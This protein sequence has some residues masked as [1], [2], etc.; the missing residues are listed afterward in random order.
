MIEGSFNSH[1]S[2][3]SS[4]DST[5]SPSILRLLKPPPIS[6]P[7]HA[8]TALSREETS[9]VRTAIWIA[10]EDSTK[11]T[12]ATGLGQYL[13]Y[14]EE[15]RLDKEKQFPVSEARMADFLTYA[16]GKVSREYTRNWFQ[17]VRWYHQYW[18]MKFEYTE[19]TPLIRSTINAVK[20]TEPSSS[21]RAKRPPVTLEL[22]RII[23]E[24]INHEDAKDVAIWA[25]SAMCF[26]GLLRLGEAVVESEKKFNKDRHVRRDSISWITDTLGRHHFQLSIPR[27]KTSITGAVVFIRGEKERA[28]DPVV[29]MNRHLMKSPTSAEAALFSYGTNG[30]KV[31]TKYQVQKRIGSILE[32]ACPG[33]KGHCFR[34]GGLLRLLLD[35]H[36]FEVARLQGRWTN[37]G[38]W[39]V[40]LREHA[41][42]LQKHL[43]VESSDWSTVAAGDSRKVEE[44]IRR[45]QRAE[46][47]AATTN[48]L[49]TLRSNLSP[50]FITTTQFTPPQSKS[51][52]T[53]HSAHNTQLGIFKR[54]R[55]DPHSRSISVERRRRIE[56]RR[57][58]TASRFVS[59]RTKWGK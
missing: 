21:K 11:K 15:K 26:A 44:E 28:I 56:T 17:G 34:I 59:V 23:Y 30:K 31:I 45:R 6:T 57:I 41:V 32:S 29:A 12:Y 24:N 58:V 47:S 7:L 35:G 50:S 2:I 54:Q 4:L 18:G 55:I 46:A 14:C 48:T 52:T 43:G 22:M 19:S 36:S 53:Q 27:T 25:C 20:K 37:G 9:R 33:F 38:C 8:F 39:Q 5:T 1:T 16:I 13:Q 10:T 49:L 40:Y 3:P 42:I 51:S